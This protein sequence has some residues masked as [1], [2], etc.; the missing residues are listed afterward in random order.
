MKKY[1]YISTGALSFAIGTIGIWVPGLPTT[2]L[3]LLAAFLWGKSSPRLHNYLM[4]NKFYN[5]YVQ[6]TFVE[7][8]MTNAGLV[9]IHLLV[10]CFMAIPFFLTS[11]L[12]LKILLIICFF[13]HVI[14]I[15]WYFKK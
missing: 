3:Y 1:L 13:I 6:K 4:E 15:R 12:W 10:L 5:K 2:P 8:K 9:K 7:K 11:Y 14:A